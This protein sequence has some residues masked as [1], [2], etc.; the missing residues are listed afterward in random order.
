MKIRVLALSIFAAI[1][2]AVV[3]VATALAVPPPGTITA[4]QDLSEPC[5]DTTGADVIVT[6][7]NGAPNTMYVAEVVGVTG[8]RVV[9]DANG[10][11]TIWLPNV[12]IE[13]VTVD[14]WAQDFSEP[15]SLP[16]EIQ[17]GTGH[18]KDL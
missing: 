5:G 13:D 3:P 14:V 18:G 12:G 10:D 7:D 16:V 17:C 6:I 11:G 4:V 9:T 2:L 1:G 15:R 8:D